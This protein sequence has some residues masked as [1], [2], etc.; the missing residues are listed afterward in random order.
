LQYSI[1]KNFLSVKSV[2]D[3]SSALKKNSTLASLILEFCNI[4]NGGIAILAESLS[5]N[6]G[7]LNLN[8]G[9]FHRDSELIYFLTLKR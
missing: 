9:N 1:G 8:I 6:T 2:K 5:V 3:L 4:Q 7:I